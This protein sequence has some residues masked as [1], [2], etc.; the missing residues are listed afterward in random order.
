MNGIL[1]VLKSVGVNDNIERAVGVGER[2]NVDL[3]ISSE[4]VVSKQSQLGSQRSC[5]VNLQKGKF[6]R[7]PGARGLAQE[8]LRA[9]E[10]PER[11]RHRNRSKVRAAIVAP[12]VLL[13]ID[14]RRLR[15]RNLPF[16]NQLVPQGWA[17]RKTYSSTNSTLQFERRHESFLPEELADCHS[18]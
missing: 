14:I 5:F 10:R 15:G 8:R 18:C 7:H 13:K 11:V 16:V 1:D 4:D 12:L 6:F 2:V 17:T 3:G 9:E